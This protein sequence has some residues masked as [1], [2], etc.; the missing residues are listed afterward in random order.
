MALVDQK[1]EAGEIEAVETEEADEERQTADV[2][3]L[4]ELLKRSLGG[5]AKGKSGGSSKGGKRAK[6]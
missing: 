6:A 5:K 2:V 3:D 4:T 1:V